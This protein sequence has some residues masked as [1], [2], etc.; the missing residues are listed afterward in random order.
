MGKYNRFWVKVTDSILWGC[1]AGLL[2]LFPVMTYLMQPA[3]DLKQQSI[4]KNIHDQKA[5][6]NTIRGEVALLSTTYMDNPREVLLDLLNQYSISIQT[7]KNDLNTI[8]RDIQ[9]VRE[10][11]L[12]YFRQQDDFRNLILTI[13]SQASRYVNLV[14]KSEN[15]LSASQQ[16]LK[17]LS[18]PETERLKYEALLS[19]GLFYNLRYVALPDRDGAYEMKHYLEKMQ[20][21]LSDAGPEVKNIFGQVNRHQVS[22]RV[23]VEN[24]Q[25]SSTLLMTMPVFHE[26]EAFEV[27]FEGWLAKA[28]QQQNDSRWAM[29][30]V[31][32]LLMIVVVI[33]MWRLRS[34]RQR[35]ELS[36]MRLR[37]FKHALDEHAIVSITDPKGRITYVNRQFL[38]ISGYEE[39]ELLGQNHRIIN[40][41]V[42]PKGFFSELWGSV[43]DNKVWHG[44]VCNRS[45]SGNLYWVHATVVPIYDDEGHLASVISVRTDITDQK[46][47]EKELSAQKERAERANQAKSNFLANMSHEIRTPMNA[48]I[49]M[50]H[51][52][53]QC[54]QDDK[55][56]GYVDKIQSAA[57]NLLAIINDILDFSKIEA[58]KLEVERIPF[59]LDNVMNNLADVAGI[60][61]AENGLPLIFDIQHDI[62]SYYL[63]DPMRLGQ[64]LLNLVNNAIKF[65]DSGDIHIG[66]SL[67]CRTG[68]RVELR[69]SVKDTG[70]GLTAEE[71]QRLFKAFSQADT[72]T[73][74]RYGGT[75]LGL[76]ICKQ[77]V[78]LM[79]GEISV[80][81]EPG[82]GSE[83]FF[84]IKADLH[85]VPE[86]EKPDLRSVRVLCIDD[87]KAARDC[88]L[89]ILDSIGL[90]ATG[91][92]SA[93]D[94]LNRLVNTDAMDEPPFDVVLV[95]W[96]MPVM[97]GFMVAQSIRNNSSLIRQPV[98]I[99][100]TGHGGEDLQSKIDPA[101]ID[102]V[103]LKPVSGSHLLDTIQECLIQQR[104]SASGS[105]ISHMFRDGDEINALLGAKV[106]IAEDNRINQEVIAG[107]LEPYG[108]ELTLVGNG[109]DAVNAVQNQQ[110]DLIM[111]DIQMP[112][113]DGFQATEQILA[114]RLPKVPPVIAMTAHAMKEDIEQC[115]AQGMNDHIAKPVDP[116]VLKRILVKW[117]EPRVISGLVPIESKKSPEPFS[118]R[119]VDLN[120]ALRSAAD[121]PKL[122]K[123]LMKQFAEDYAQGIQPALDYMA[124]G[125]W[126][127]LERWL[128]TLKGTSA[129]LGMTAI[130]EETRKTELIFQNNK[131]PGNHDLQLLTGMLVTMVNNVLSFV[132]DQEVIAEAASEQKAIL[133]DIFRNAM[134]PLGQSDVNPEEIKSRVHEIRSMLT[135]G[136]AEV[137]DKVP[138]LM[139]L[140]QNDEQLLQHGADLMELVDSFEFD[141]ALELLTQFEK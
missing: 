65:T 52:A 11:W 74:R 66:A 121:N 97:D 89:G 131:L 112:Q 119:G 26:L 61:A 111:M 135:D 69:F 5:I 134:M 40:S 104:K 130:A 132:S 25:D 68:N 48:V 86:Q 37:A 84:T 102:A 60:K 59:R 117:I 58:G 77:L 90:N 7:V 57:Q 78:E 15:V 64:V 109:R 127:E 138:E 118:I 33:I 54:S 98:I 17:M 126:V 110:F 43:F 42:H 107:L 27:I 16:S 92:T 113:L 79:E 85:Y 1:L 125:N 4:L 13:S 12:V 82:K 140:L 70:I 96:K 20:T 81:S 62:P 88:M 63:G 137:L 34:F 94:G 51:L 95:D 76:A 128:H 122:L 106:L 123:R 99:L 72:S 139:E 71:Q 38:D 124:E 80:Y 108:L 19:E 50:S 8:P 24:L 53:R 14:S 18:L 3:A 35:L 87:D 129:T 29:L 47:I 73:T 116:D 56:N 114:M 2:L 44:D 32:T 100:V 75:G 6:L 136:D 105:S 46:L 55:V 39:Q 9:D 22:L 23:S 101:L 115:L 67:L 83:F 120:I 45:K 133:D 28:R 49:G 31:I 141:Q 41:G 36:N 93:P 91:E 10:Q 21:I 30:A 103:L